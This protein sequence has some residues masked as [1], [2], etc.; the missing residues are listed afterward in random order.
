MFRPRHR[1]PGFGE[2]SEGGEIIYLSTS[3][4]DAG[5]HHSLATSATV[6]LVRMKAIP[7]CTVTPIQVNFLL[8]IHLARLSSLMSIKRWICRR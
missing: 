2:A 6:W 4:I 7:P 8:L 3:W 5:G 1:S